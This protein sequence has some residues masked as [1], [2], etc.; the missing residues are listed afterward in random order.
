MRQLLLPL[1]ILLSSAVFSQ[2]CI[3]L[4]AIDGTPAQSFAPVG[5][6]MIGATPDLIAGNGPW[7][8]GSGYV[9]FDVDGTSL[10]GGEMGLF[11]LNGGTGG[12]LG[13]GWTTALAG[14]TIGQTYSISMEWQ[15]NTLSNPPGNTIVYAG[16]ELYLELYGTPY[17]F[18]S[19]GGINDQWQVAT[20]T[21]TATTTNPVLTLRVKEPATGPI[22]GYGSSIV[23]DNIF[24]SIN[25]NPVSVSLTD[26]TICVGDCVDLTATFVATGTPTFQ[27]DNGITNTT[28]G[29]VNV[30]PTTTTTYQ[31]IIDDGGVTDT[32]TATVTVIS[33]QDATITGVAGPF[34]ATDPA[35]TM[36]AVDPGGA[37]T[38]TGITNGTTGQF[39]PATAGAGT[40]TIYYTISGSCGDIDSIDVVVNTVD[41]AAF[42]F[43]Q[44]D[45][46]PTDPD[47]TPTITG[48][49]GGTFTIDNGGVINAAT[50]E[51]DIAASGVG[52]YT[53]TYTTNGPCPATAT[54]TITIGLSG[55][56]TITSNAGP[57]CEGDAAVTLSSVDPGG[58]WSGPGITDAVAGTFDPSTAGAG[59]HTITYTIPGACGDTDQVTIIVNPQDDATFSLSSTIICVND[60]NPTATVTG[61]P[62]GT[63]S[64]DNGG[65]INSTTGEI[66]VAGSG[67]GTYT[68]TYT[69]NGQCPA[70]STVL[71]AI[72]DPVTP[73]INAAGPYC[74]N[75]PSD[76]ITVNTPGGTWSGPGINASTGEFTPIIAGEGVHQIIYTIPGSCGGADTIDV[77]VSGV[78]TAD[79]GLDTTISAG[80][81]AVLTGSGGGTYLWSPTDFLDC[82]S[83]ETVT[84][85]P[86]VTTTYYM[87]VTNAYGCTASDSVIVNV[88]NDFEVWIPNIFNP[89]GSGYNDVF[90]VR[91]KGI[92]EIEF[93]IFDR[94]GQ[95]VFES[96]SVDNGWDGTINGEPANGGVY[97]YLVRAYSYTS[98]EPAEYKGNVTLIRQ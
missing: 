69:T 75:W 92:A 85:S 56:A 90:Y 68:V 36:T 78:P 13:E 66:D 38:G 28:A 61:T 9:T 65:I 67:A 21:F 51:V 10:S 31:V 30:C 71:V 44:T 19:T 50:G 81:A 74:I 93:L 24:C 29:P 27:W 2:T 12:G 57:F 33:P 86:I 46:C 39:D 45:Y 79:A 18:T 83:C 3:D 54:F 34:C 64:I 43:A 35:V 32:A 76:V 63:F 15:Q 4:P 89:N 58:T 40:H 96:S 48:T 82:S 91:G 23:V 11:L 77:F 8:G 72:T 49:T 59:T 73:V 41:N 25:P 7:P 14:L 16:G 62:G 53:I 55:D 26:T 94:W 47:P 88:T 95:L 17:I 22:G 37:W 84:A 1:L 6:S 42:T 80:D 70:T 98:D 52:S 60:A 5:Y 97:V 87:T 20:F